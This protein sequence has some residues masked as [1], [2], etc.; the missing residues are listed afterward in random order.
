MCCVALVLILLLPDIYCQL[1]DGYPNCDHHDLHTLVVTRSSEKLIPPS[2]KKFWKPE[3]DQWTEQQREEYDDYSSASKAIMVDLHN[4][5]SIARHPAEL[6]QLPEDM[7]VGA[8]CLPF[9]GSHL[10]SQ[11]KHLSSFRHPLV[12]AACVLLLRNT[13]LEHCNTTVCVACNVPR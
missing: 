12:L 1:A 11:R 7:N 8:V 2:S 3:F 13:S 5:L 4:T 10:C 9:S 6:V